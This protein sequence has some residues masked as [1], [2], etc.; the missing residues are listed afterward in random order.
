MV[1]FDLSR[2][3]TQTWLNQ[4]AMSFKTLGTEV[5]L[6]FKGVLSFFLKTLLA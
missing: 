6:L 2:K 1:S 3:L 4:S 5:V